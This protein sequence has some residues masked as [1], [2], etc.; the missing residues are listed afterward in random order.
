M[1]YLKML[2][3]ILLF[4]VSISGIAQQ[5]QWR[6]A[7]R[8][9]MYTETQ[10]MKTW[11]AS[12]PQL[13]W[14]NETIGDGYGSPVISSDMLLING[15]IDSVSHVFA[16]DLNGKLIWKTP[17]GR[18]FT[19]NGFSNRFPG[20][21][22]TPTVVDDV[23]YIC[24]GNGRIACLDKKTGKEKWSKDM[25]TD[26]NGVIPAFGYSE[27]L[28]V[29]NSVLYCFPGGATN[30]AVALDRLTGKTIWTS[31]LLGDTI[32]YCS[33]LLI[34]L[35]SRNILVTFS[36]YYIM[37]IDAKTG[38]LLWSQKQENVKHKQQ[39]NTPIFADG[40]I[41]YVAGD[42]NGVVKLELSAD[43]KTIKEV[44]RTENVSNTFSGFLKINDHLFTTDRTQ[45]LK[46]FDTKTGQVID[47]LKMN[48][49]AI[50]A[51][52]DRMYVYSENGDVQLIKATGSKM[53]SVGKFKVEVG[54][55]EHFAHPVISKGVLYVRHGKILLAYN[56]KQI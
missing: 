19:G 11:P 15:E 2:P 16:F 52:D 44:W 21:R 7:N 50:I 18:E 4:C 22:S 33:P 9:G 30:N 47:S 45:K 36:N 10:L 48:R 27:S 29:D 1:K 20:S 40:N 6:G 28:L 14:T 41:Y 8:D 25:I 12:G 49:G 5:N 55:R 46:C 37:G 13:L 53:E 38:E 35:P 31:K 34:R 24:S 51:A 39:C 32:S 26:F 23:I 54:T 42:G 43:G 17:N 56:I 3:A